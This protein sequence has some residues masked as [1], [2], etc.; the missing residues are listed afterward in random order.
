MKKD[1]KAVM[2]PVATPSRKEPLNTARNTPKDLSM[3]SASKLWLLSPAG[4]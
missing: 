1:M 4:W 2:T 3:A